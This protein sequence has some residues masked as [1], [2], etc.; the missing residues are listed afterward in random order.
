MTAKIVWKDAE[1]LD[2]EISSGAIQQDDGLASL[3]YLCLFTDARAA[4]D[5]ELPNGSTDKRGWPGDTYLDTAWGSR[6]WLLDREKLTNDTKN[7]AV[8]Y[9]I[10]AL[11]KLKD[12]GYIKS[13]TVAGSIPQLNT[14]VLNI[15]LT[16]PNGTPESLTVSSRWSAQYGI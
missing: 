9:A 4:A 16:K 13:V 12:A 2:I 3:V 6:L 1:G 8:N 10:E 11:N 5:D 14:L 7:K 15:T